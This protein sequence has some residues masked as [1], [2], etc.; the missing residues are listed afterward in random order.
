MPETGTMRKGSATTVGPFRTWTPLTTA[1]ALVGVLLQATAKV[2]HEALH[3]V[4]VSV[5]TKMAA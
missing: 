2:T 3:G 5:A 4:E 1:I